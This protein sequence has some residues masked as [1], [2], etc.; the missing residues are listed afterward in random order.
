MA[1]LESSL[2]STDTFTA[3]K[4]LEIEVY[5]IQTISLHLHFSI[6]DYKC[7][8]LQLTHSWNFLWG[9]K[10]SVSE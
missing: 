1:I 10:L 8:F 3:I 2:E 4:S 9:E 6:Q 5:K 7:I